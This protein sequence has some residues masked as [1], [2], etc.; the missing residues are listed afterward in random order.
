MEGIKQWSYRPEIFPRGIKFLSETTGWPIAAHNRYWS[1]D[2]V[3]DKANG[4]NYTFVKETLLSI[5][6]DQK[7]WNDFLSV[8][9][10]WGLKM[11]EQDWLNIQTIGTVALQTDLTLGERWLQQMNNAAQN[12]NITIQYCMAL[13]RHALQSLKNPAVT[14]IIT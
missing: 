10:Q 9:K 13:P 11:Y 14:Q 2:N 6:D 12:L 4:G 3:Y 7:F 8:A 1:S 5:P